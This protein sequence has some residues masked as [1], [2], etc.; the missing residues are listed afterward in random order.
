MPVG[1]P[2]GNDIRPRRVI[3]P[4]A[5]Q[6]AAALPIQVSGVNFRGGTGDGK[7][8]FFFFFEITAESGGALHLY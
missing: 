8:P 7:A 3:P 6:S 2:I 1:L 5:A 4:F